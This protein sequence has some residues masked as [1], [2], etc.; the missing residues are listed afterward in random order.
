MLLDGVN[1]I[2]RL[3]LE[4]DLVTLISHILVRLFIEDLPQTDVISTISMLAHCICYLNSAI[5]PIIYNHMNSKIILLFFDNLNAP[6]QSH[7]PKTFLPPSLHNF[8]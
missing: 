1:D 8:T 7:T 6:I 4:L 2:R 5:N 3:D